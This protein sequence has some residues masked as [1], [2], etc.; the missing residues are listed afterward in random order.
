MISYL[1]QF[2]SGDMPDYDQPPKGLGFYH[3][4]SNEW[5]A[6][7]TFLNSKRAG[8]NGSM[9]LANPAGQNTPMIQISTGNDAAQLLGGVDIDTAIYPEIESVCHTDVA[10]RPATWSDAATAFYE[11]LTSPA[12]EG[13]CFHHALASG[14]HI[15]AG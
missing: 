7:H 10:H 15:P 9:T 6:K 4:Y 8:I 14:M 12:A 1:T 11:A 2:S 5:E 3:R 13:N